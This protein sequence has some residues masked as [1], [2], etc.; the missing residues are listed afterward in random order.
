[1]TT[2]KAD[3]TTKWASQAITM[4]TRTQSMFDDNTTY[5]YLTEGKWY[6]QL[7]TFVN[8]QDLLTDWVD[9]L[10]STV[11]TTVSQGSSGGKILSDWRVVNTDES[12]YYVY[13]DWPIPVNLAYT[14]ANLMT[15]GTK[16][17]PVGD[18]NWFPTTK[19]SFDMAAEHTALENE[20]QTGTAV[21][22]HGTGPETFALSQNY[23]N[24]FNPSTVINFTIPKA[25][26][27]SLKV[28]N[29]LGQEVATLLDGFKTAQT[30]NV[31]FDAAGLSSGV[32]IYTLKTGDQSISKKM[33]LLK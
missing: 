11:L 32:Y 20:L 27:V 10:K 5:P 30:Y 16:G 24:P 8:S 9:T 23:P 19:A 13:A 21:K 6:K 1:L 22:N 14:D 15:G 26:N 4:N 7:P 33:L 29:V 28:Y 2:A 31:R 18:L 12:T 25:G 3:G 17:E